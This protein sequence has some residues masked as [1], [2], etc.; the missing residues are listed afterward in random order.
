MIK[1][2]AKLCHADLKSGISRPEIPGD[3]ETAEK[4]QIINK[5]DVLFLSDYVTSLSSREK[6]KG[7]SIQ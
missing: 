5:S 4:L 1:I 2:I 7:D 6:L 3:I